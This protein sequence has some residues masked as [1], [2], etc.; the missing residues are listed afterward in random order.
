MEGNYALP[1]LVRFGL[2]DS[3]FN[4]YVDVADGKPYY[5]SKP[6]NPE[7][8]I[9]IR[10]ISVERVWKLQFNLSMILA[11]YKKY[12]PK[13]IV[14]SAEDLE[15]YMGANAESPKTEFADVVGM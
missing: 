5:H 2:P 10:G 1:R 8:T 13:K 11:Y 9:I 3:I 4:L 7:D 15:R 14:C 6:M 12:K